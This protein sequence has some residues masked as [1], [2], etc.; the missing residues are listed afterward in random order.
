MPLRKCVCG[1]KFRHE[2]YG[3]T[4]PVCGIVARKYKEEGKT[5]EEIA[6]MYKVPERK[7]TCAWLICVDGINKGRSYEIRSGRSF[8]GS[9]D[10][11]D[12][13]ILGDSTIDEHRHAGIAFDPL[14]QTAKLLPGESHGLVYLNDDA[15]YVPQDLKSHA[16]ISIGKSEFMYIPFCDD[17][18]HWGARTTIGDDNGISN[19]VSDA[20]INQQET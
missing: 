3:D 16:R 9:A 6:A 12:I 5:P 20:G 19:E 4:C 1:H 18:Y 14:T 7:Y 15:I 13:Q 11:M 17:N 2:K 8:I 10:N